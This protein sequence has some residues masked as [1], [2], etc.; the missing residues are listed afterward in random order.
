MKKQRQ[1]NKKSREAERARQRHNRVVVLEDKFDRMDKTIEVLRK[2]IATL[3]G[4]REDSVSPEPTIAM[5][6]KTATEWG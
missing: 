4:K 5:V 2:R 6:S 1:P 3:E